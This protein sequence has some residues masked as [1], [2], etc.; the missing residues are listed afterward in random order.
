MHDFFNGSI[1]NFMGADFTMNQPS[2]NILESENGFRLELA[3]PGLEKE[4]FE[5]NVEKDQLTI[6][7]TVEK[8]ETQ[9]DGK[10]TRRE[11]NFGSFT[12]TFRLP[13]TVDV[14]Q[15]TGNYEHGILKVNL[16]KLAEKAA[17][18]PRSIEIG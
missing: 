13:E 6:T 18:Q 9:N 16:P 17:D 4:N 14:T 11:F 15:I 1:N 2:V 3:A 12:R 10:Y 8:T 5:V 7:A